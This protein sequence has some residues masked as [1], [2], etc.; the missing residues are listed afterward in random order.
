MELLTITLNKKSF[1]AS[2][3]S[4]AEHRVT[5]QKPHHRKGKKK[6]ETAYCKHSTK[7]R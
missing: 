6:N 2:P 3:S 1:E 4:L 5:R 7:I